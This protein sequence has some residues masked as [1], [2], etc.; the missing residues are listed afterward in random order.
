MSK[1]LI[2]NWRAAPRMLSMWC[3]AAIA[4]LNGAWLFIGW[5]NGLPLFVG[6]QGHQTALALAVLGAV[7][8]LV[9]QPSVSGK[10]PD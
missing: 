9:A 6:P 10:K 1:Y 3:F 2:D 7:L 4:G 5:I 8:R